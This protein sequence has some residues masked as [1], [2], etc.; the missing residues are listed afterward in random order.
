MKTG[1]DVII[2]ALLGAEEFGFATAPL[3]VSGCIMMRVCHL[4]T[5]PVGVATQNPV[6]RE[7]FTGKAEYIV[8]FMEFI[9]RRCASTSPPSATARSTR[10]SVAPNC[11]TRTRPSS[12][13]GAR[14]QPRA[15]PRGAPLREDEP[16]RHARNQD[17]ELE[18]HFDVQLIER[19]QDVIAH[20]GQLT[21]TCRSATPPARL[22]TMLGHHVTKAHGEH[23]L[24]ENSIDVR[25]SGSAGQSFGAFMPAG[26]TLR[27]E[28]DSN[29]Y[30][31]KGP[32]RGHDRR[33]PPR[34]ST[35]AASEKRH[36][37]ETS[38]A[39]AAP[40]GRCS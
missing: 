19:A 36:R 40:R 31:G 18:D 17:H 22:G 4:D 11:S 30:V 13:E 10:S 23:G 20:G 9:G 38:S 12:I 7:R 8:N 26:I 3:V 16:R 2:G 1:R 15:H 37:R 5:C 27:L 24:P 25:L 29:D 32:C 28:G 39:T 6:L 33:A 35:F 21:S 34:G 14:P